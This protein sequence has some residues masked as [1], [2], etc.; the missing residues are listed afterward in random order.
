MTDER[1]EQILQRALA[2][3]IEDH[4]AY[5]LSERSDK[6]EGTGLDDAKITYDI[7]NEKARY[8]SMSAIIKIGAAA[9]CAAIITGAGIG[10]SR[11][12]Q[13]QINDEPASPD[14]AAN[15]EAIDIETNA[16]AA[17]GK[18]FAVMLGDMELTNEGV[19]L[20]Y[21][22]GLSV[23]Y[24]TK[25]EQNELVN[26]KVDKAFNGYAKKIVR[27]G[28]VKYSVWADLKCEGED[29]ETV[30]YSINKG[31]FAVVELKDKSDVVK[32]GTPYKSADGSNNYGV[33]DE[34]FWTEELLYQYH[35]DARAAY[36]TEFTLDYE[37]Q[38]SKSFCVDICEETNDTELYEK[39]CNSENDS[40]LRAEGF[41]ELMDGVEITCTVHY[42]DGTQSSKVLTVEGTT[43]THEILDDLPSDF[44]AEQKE[45]VFVYKLK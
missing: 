39:L 25:G 20:D 19:I 7:Q 17:A 33:N 32:S 37:S 9:A 29:I 6:K 44:D 30:T 38:Q 3:E 36:Y 8:S 1:F 13:R 45:A 27:E 26:F 21:S 23:G 14:I 4:E 15:E 12:L 34:N 35:A 31:S 22:T 2:P 43:S 40:E 11:F 28:S 24:E 41:T 42:A 5:V 18:P 10:G 16:D